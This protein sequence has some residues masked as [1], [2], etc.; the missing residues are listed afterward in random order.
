M[1]KIICKNCDWTKLVKNGVV[2]QQQRYKCKECGYNFVEWDKRIKQNLIPKKALAIL[3]YSLWKASFRFIWK[4]L[5]VDHT[6]IYRRIVKE[7]EDMIIDKIDGEIKEI[8][9]DEM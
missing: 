2:R 5:W 4:L 3:L 8:E 7:W 9:F 6:L 1:K